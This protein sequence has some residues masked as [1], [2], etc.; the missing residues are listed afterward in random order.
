MCAQIDS[1]YAARPRLALELRGRH[2]NIFIDDVCSVKL[3]DAL[4]LADFSGRV[5]A[6]LRYPERWLCAAEHIMAPWCDADALRLLNTLTASAQ[7]PQVR[8]G[9]LARG[10]AP[11]PAQQ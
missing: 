11:A 8:P 6:A 9:S 1:P 7:P 3:L 10:N 4:P 5:V 2:Y